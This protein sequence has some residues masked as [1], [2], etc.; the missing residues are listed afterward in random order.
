M[1]PT[2]KPT[3]P[4]AD[5]LKT[6]SQKFWGL[7]PGDIDNNQVEDIKGFKN[8]KATVE[9]PAYRKLLKGLGKGRLETYSDR[10]L[11]ILTAD[12][13]ETHEEFKDWSRGPKTEKP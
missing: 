13:H 4:K 5:S 9:D 6:D 3:H 11:P 7:N 10:T 2:V 8:A 1:Q 12:D